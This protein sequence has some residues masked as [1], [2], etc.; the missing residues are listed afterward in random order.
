M[1]KNLLVNALSAQL[2]GGQTYLLNLFDSSQDVWNNYNIIFL[3]SDR[4]Q[5]VFRRKFSNVISIGKIGDIFFSRFIWE[6]TSL[7]NLLKKQ[8]I[9]LL[10]SPGG[11]LPFFLPKSKTVCVSQN[12]LPFMSDQIL[13]SET[14]LEKFRLILLRFLQGYAFKKADAVIFLSHFASSTI[15]KALGPLKN[16]IIIPHGTSTDFST[17][18]TSPFNF[19]YMLYVSTFFAYKHQLT[20][21]QAYYDLRK[22]KN[23]QTKLILVGSNKGRYA[24]KVANLIK[25]LGLESDVLMTGNIAHSDLPGMM[26]N[27][28]LNIFASSC[29]NCPII[30]LEYLTAQR[31]VLCSN[32]EPMPE[33]GKNW[34]TYFSPYNK[35]ELTTGIETILVQKKIAAT[36]SR[37]EIAALS[38]RKTAEK[39]K[40]FIEKILSH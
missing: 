15:S 31:P 16:T 34:V 2:G 38:W 6:N 22:Q 5:E 14:M 10:F 13:Q 26:Q 21:V 37:E 28:E 1:K 9:D 25:Q 33:F 32:L 30:L 12:M 17:K 4:N 7:L 27:S 35:E 19:K 24:T 18:T 29:E 39:T 11:L 8:K 23:L 36:M 3:V 20:V 40:N